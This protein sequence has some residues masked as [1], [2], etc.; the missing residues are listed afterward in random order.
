MVHVFFLL[1]DRDVDIKKPFYH[2][3]ALE[4]P[5]KSVKVGQTSKFVG[6]IGIL[7]AYHTR[8]KIMKKFLSLP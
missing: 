4:M 5:F 6:H 8:R 1:R 7:V 2:S 3:F